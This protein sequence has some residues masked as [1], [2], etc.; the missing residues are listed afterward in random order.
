M[1][2]RDHMAGLVPQA[3]AMVLLDEVVDCDERRIRC[4]ARSHRDVANPL[5][6]E[7]ALP[8]LAAVEYAAQAMAAHF[9]LNAELAGNA[10]LGL[11]GAL[12]DVVCNTARL[13]DVPGPLIVTCERLSHDRAGSIYAFE[14]AA[15]DD[16]RSLVSGRAT[17]VQRRM[18]EP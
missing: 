1:N 15:E 11:L 2:A 14:L 4:R 8:A 7:G 3:G 12:R 9:S 10:T 13:D 16:G 5:A 18:E 17:V 6:H